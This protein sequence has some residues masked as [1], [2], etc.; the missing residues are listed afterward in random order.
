MTDDLPVEDDPMLLL[1]A[2]SPEHLLE[3]PKKCK[4]RKTKEAKR[5]TDLM[6]AID[7]PKRPSCA[8]SECAEIKTVHMHVR[9]NSTALWIR[10]DCID[11]LVSY[12]ADEHYYQGV[13]RS[14]PLTAVAA[15]D[16]EIEFDYNDKAWDCNINVGVDKGVTLRLCA[17]RI[18][19]EMYE[20]TAASDPTTFDVWWSK[21][22]VTIKRKACREYLSLWALAAVQGSRQDFED[23]VVGQESPS[24]KRRIGARC[25]TAVAASHPANGVE[26][27][28]AA[29]ASAIGVDEQEQL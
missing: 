16:Y 27:S 15:K 10:L 1:G 12:A 13:S 8:G 21:A 11:W 14:D 4:P 25:E 2:C 20:K 22:G 23:E 19:K 5:P 3:T 29:S 7:M 26:E 17:T 6:R 24:K 9:P 18:T 28:Q